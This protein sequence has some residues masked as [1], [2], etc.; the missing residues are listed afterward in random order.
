MSKCVQFYSILEEKH[1][2]FYSYIPELL[3]GLLI[4]C[5]DILLNEISNGFRL[6]WP[7]QP[8]LARAAILVVGKTSFRMGIKIPCKATCR[9]I[10]IFTSNFKFDF[11]ILFNGLARS[12]KQRAADQT[13]RSV[14]SWKLLLTVMMPHVDFGKVLAE[15]LFRSF[16]HLRL[17]LQFIRYR[18]TC[19]CVDNI[20]KRKTPSQ[21]GLDIY[22]GEPHLSSPQYRQSD[23]DDSRLSESMA[24]AS[25]H[26]TKPCSDQVLSMTRHKTVTSH[27]RFR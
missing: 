10:V 18:R 13:N 24:I 2:L 26:I 20:Y 23:F 12:I 8:S 16:E 14:D 21:L 3:V 15:T 9:P 27:H 25:D 7:K 6:S 5:K 4:N 11:A 22:S 17:D 1:Q 19:S